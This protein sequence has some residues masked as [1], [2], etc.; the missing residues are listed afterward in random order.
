MSFLQSGS[1]QCW[2]LGLDATEYR[3]RSGFDLHLWL[4]DSK[5]AHWEY[6]PARSERRLRGEMQQTAGCLKPDE[7]VYR[8]DV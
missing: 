5:L 1:Q 2:R 3:C 6:A 7:L 8:P 4:A